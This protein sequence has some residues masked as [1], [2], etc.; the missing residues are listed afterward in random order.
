MEPG[1]IGPSYTNQDNQTTTPPITNTFETGGSSSTK[2]IPQYVPAPFE[3]YPGVMNTTINQKPFMIEDYLLQSP[4]VEFL[5]DLMW[6]NFVFGVDELVPMTIIPESGNVNELSYEPDP[7]EPYTS[8]PNTDQNVTMGTTCI[9]EV[10]QQNQPRPHDQAQE[11]HIEANDR[12]LEGFLRFKPPKFE[13]KPDAHQAESWLSKINKIFSILNYSEEQKTNFFTYLFEEAAHNWWRTVEHKWTRNHTSK[14]WDN[15]LQEFEEVASYVFTANQALRVEEDIKAL[16]KKEE[17]EK[18]LRKHN[19]FEDDNRKRKFEKRTQPVRQGEAVKG[20]LTCKDN[21]FL[22]NDECEKSFCKLKEMLTS[23]PVLAL[24]EGTEGFVLYTDP[25][26]E[27]FRWVLMQN[28]KVIAYASRKLKNHELNYPTHDL[29]LGAIVFALAKWRHYLYGKANVVTD[30]LSRKIT[31]ACL[32]MKAVRAWIHIHSPGHL[33]GL[34]IEPE[35][36]T[37]VKQNQELEQEDSK[38][39]TDTNFVTNSQG[40]QFYHDRICVPSSMKKE[41]MEKLHQYR[42]S[43]HL[44][45]SKMYQEIKNHFWWNGIKRD[46]VDFISQCLSCQMIKAEHQR[47]TGLLQP[48]PIPEWKWDQITMDFVTGLPQLPG[49]FNSIW[50]IVDRLT[51][52]AH[53]IPIS[54]KYWVED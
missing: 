24:P 2:N 19:L 42:I 45:G 14:M 51:K 27:G 15:F 28:Y 18:K 43:I 20:K 34:R 5:P 12:A 31:M 22:W 4:E 46:I 8:L 9:N 7:V 17:E 35:F 25:S 11:H 37:I 48:L 41:I 36:H 47:P 6:E 23:A 10:L 13:G 49:G 32:E 40:I 21:P 39:R 3:E 30:A 1:V 54:H 26:K 29:E 33:A 16:L 52:S 38:I 50:V 53:F 44:G